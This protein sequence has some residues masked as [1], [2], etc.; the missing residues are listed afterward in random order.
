MPT[1]RALRCCTGTSGDAVRSGHGGYE[2]STSQGHWR[3]RAVVIASG[4]FGVAARARSECRP[5]PP[6]LRASRRCNTGT[7][8]SC[9]MAA[10]WSSAPRRA[11]FRLR[12]RSR[13]RAANRAV[14]RRARAHA[15]HLSRPRH[16]WWMDATAPMDVRF[17]E[18]DDIERARRLPSLQLVGTPGACNR[19]P[20]QPC[21]DGRRARRAACRAGERQGAVLGIAC[22]TSAPSPTSR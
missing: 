10:C 12:G 9:P 11:A 16:Q 1:S 4:A 3:C 5:P 13:R 22:R 19:R 14:G 17:D 2:V 20:Q 15:A 7:P 21:A 8:P 6:A 18:V